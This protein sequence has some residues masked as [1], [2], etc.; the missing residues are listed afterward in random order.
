MSFYVSNRAARRLCAG[1]TLSLFCGG[2]ALADCAQ[3][4]PVRVCTEYSNSDD[5]FTGKVASIKQWPQP[6]DP[7]NIE[8]WFYTVEVGRTYRGSPGNKIELWWGNDPD[9]YPVK[10][11]QNYLFFVRKN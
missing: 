9:G 2:A 4:H 6:P 11:G 5:V 1:L 7:N 10:E 3:P 8:G